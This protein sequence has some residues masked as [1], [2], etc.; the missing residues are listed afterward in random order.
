MSMIV[1]NGLLAYI[2]DRVQGLSS[3]GEWDSTDEDDS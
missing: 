2:T 1:A 3:F